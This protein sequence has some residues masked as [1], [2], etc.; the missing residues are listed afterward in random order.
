MF[1]III[2]WLLDYIFM[3]VILMMSILG[4]VAMGL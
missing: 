1:D 4:T 2:D 3:V